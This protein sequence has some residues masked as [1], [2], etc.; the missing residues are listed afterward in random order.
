MGLR[1]EVVGIQ[2]S[3][4]MEIDS[5]LPTR[6]INPVCKAF[7]PAMIAFQVA[8]EVDGALACIK[9]QSGKYFPLRTHEQRE[10][11]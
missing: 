1:V 2:E 10:L 3:F 11:G 8:D 4:Q 6:L 9:S 5:P 7:L